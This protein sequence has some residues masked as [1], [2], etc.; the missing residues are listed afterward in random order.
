MRRR[1]DPA[2]LDMQGTQVVYELDAEIL[3][4]NGGRTIM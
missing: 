1:L 3:A 2:P 4:T